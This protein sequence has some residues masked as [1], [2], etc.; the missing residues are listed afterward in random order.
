M[1]AAITGVPRDLVDVPS[2]IDYDELLA[3]DDM[4]YRP[5]DLDDT[6]LAPACEVGG[7]G[8]A[9]PARRIVQ[10]IQPFGESGD[11]VVQSICQSD[12]S[13]AVEA[14]AEVIARRLCGPVI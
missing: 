12:L 8:S 1:V 5:D 6:R 10:V 4:Q 9:D 3:D 7:V 11:G 2:L 13:P 14:I